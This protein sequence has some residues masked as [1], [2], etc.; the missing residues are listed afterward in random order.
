[1]SAYL[2][3]DYGE[4]V[5]QLEQW[6]KAASPEDEALVERVHT[7]FSKIDGIAHGKSRKQL[8]VAAAA[9]LERIAPLRKPE[10]ARASD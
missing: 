5:A 3:G 1:M 4:S 7:A 10:G 8:V 6:A 9:L 2:K